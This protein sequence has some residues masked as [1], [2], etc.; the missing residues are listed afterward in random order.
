MF[1]RHLKLL[2]FCVALV[3]LPQ[4]A[5]AEGFLPTLEDVPLME[6]LSVD[7]GDVMVFD[8][9]EGRIAEAE[10]G[11]PV[12]RDKVIEFYRTTLPHLGWMPNGKGGFEREQEVLELELSPPGAMPV[13]VKFRIKP[14]GE[15]RK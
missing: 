8:T 4:M 3:V 15:A 7:D 12:E 2:A 5:L 6:G 9:P 14:L 1:L 13:K 10:A 11:G